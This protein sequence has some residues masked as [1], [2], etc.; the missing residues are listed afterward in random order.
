MKRTPVLIA[1]V[2]AAAATVGSVWIFSRRSSHNEMLQLLSQLKE[3]SRS[4]NS[5]FNPQA[6]LRYYDSMLA[7]GGTE[8]EIMMLKYNKTEALLRLGDEEQVIEIMEN[9]IKKNERDAPVTTRF[10]RAMLCLAYFGLGE[11]TNCI[12]GHAS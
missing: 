10:A 12:A 7:R 5:T 3:K 2:I 4:Q 6:K 8:S 11:M 9:F 1:I